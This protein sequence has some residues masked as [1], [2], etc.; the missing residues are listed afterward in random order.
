MMVGVQVCVRATPVSIPL[1]QS[2]DG[3]LLSARLE[4][5]QP[6]PDRYSP[7]DD[8]GYEERRRANPRRRARGPRGA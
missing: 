4:R 6:P 3:P 2:Q 8:Y 1:P 5:P 7:T